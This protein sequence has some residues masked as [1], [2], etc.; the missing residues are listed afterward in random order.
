MVTQAAVGWVRFLT[1]R[2]LFVV[3]YAPNLVR[4]R[5]LQLISHLVR[6]GHDLTVATLWTGADEQADLRGVQEL[7]PR[8]VARRLARLRSAGNCLAAVPSRTPLQAVYCWHPGLAADLAA[9]HANGQIA[10]F[11]VIHVEHLRGANYGL[12]LKRQLAGSPAAARPPVVWDAVDCISHLFS[13][14]ARKSRSLKGRLMTRF[15]L[16]RTRRYE[17]WLVGQFDHVT[18]TSPVDRQALEALWQEHGASRNGHGAD[19][20]AHRLTV[21]PNGVDL[22]YFTPDSAPRNPATVVLSGKMSYHANVSAALHLVNDIMPRVWAVKPDA[23]VVIAGKDPAQQVRQLALQHP[24]RVEVTGTVPDIR[25]Y[26]RQATVAV[27]PVLYSAGIQ[28][29]VLEAMACGAPVIANHQAVSALA[30]R[31]GT[32]LL[33]AGDAASFA[34]E[35]LALLANPAAQQQ[36]GQ[37][38]RAYVERRHSW[39]AVAGQLEAVYHRALETRR[40]LAGASAV[41]GHDARRDPLQQAAG[42]S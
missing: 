28:N 27:A 33:V 39:R 19:S 2:V 31:A 22:D 30:V 24:G 9:Q 11:D 34:A 13:Q 14:A 37:A 4:V 1:M 25:P 18:V 17:G 26:L 20:A 23:Q 21:L 36:I 41:P 29:K 15:E 32:D 12:W 10:P 16:G 8:V 3:P 7:G 5:P 35:I 6:H 38:G 42:G 40:S